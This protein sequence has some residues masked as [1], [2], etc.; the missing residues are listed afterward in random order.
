MTHFVKCWP[1]SFDLVRSGRKSFEVR[2]NDRDYKPGDQVVLAEW[3]PTT[4]RTTGE[5]VTVHIRT[6][7]QGRWGLPADVCVFDWHPESLGHFPVRPNSTSVS[8]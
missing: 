8:S 1:S 6:I 2:K 7:V 4:G 5:A 3:S